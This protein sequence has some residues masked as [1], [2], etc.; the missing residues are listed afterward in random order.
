MGSEEVLLLQVGA[1]RNT[2]WP[3]SWP[4][5]GRDISFQKNYM[6]IACCYITETMFLFLYR[7]SNKT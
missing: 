2:K 4:L 3:P 7:P 5:I 6:F 1:I